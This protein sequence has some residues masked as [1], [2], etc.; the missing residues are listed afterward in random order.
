MG[1]LVFNPAPMPPPPCASELGCAKLAT[2]W[3]PPRSERVKGASSLRLALCS[4]PRAH[5]NPGQDRVMLKASFRRRKRSKGRGRG[6]LRSRGT[7]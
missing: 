7:G 1:T 2:G 6:R 5:P 3:K 4:Y